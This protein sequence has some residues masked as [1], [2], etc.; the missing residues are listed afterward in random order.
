MSS[1][2][3]IEEGELPS[4]PDRGEEEDLEEGEILESD[5][6]ENGE[7]EARGSP[8]PPKLT[9]NQQERGQERERDESSQRNTRKVYRKNGK[10]VPLSVLGRVA[11]MRFVDINVFAFSLLVS[12]N[13]GVV[14]GSV[15]WKGICYVAAGV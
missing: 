6:E 1:A 12:P 2:P 10:G 13:D 14:Y 8:N 3:G 9:S 15:I 5:N 11:T 4:S 7:P